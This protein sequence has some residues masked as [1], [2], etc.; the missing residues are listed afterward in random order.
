VTDYD[1]NSLVTSSGMD[2]LTQSYS[3]H[4]GSNLVSEMTAVDGTKT[5]Y[6]YDGMIRLQ[7]VTDPVGATTSYQYNID[8]NIRSH[9]SHIKTTSTFPADPL[10]F[11]ELNSLI[12]ISYLDGLGR[13][14]QSVAVDQA[15]DGNSLIVAV[16]YDDQ[17][18][19]N[20]R[21]EPYSA[22][23][24][25]FNSLFSTQ[26]F[27]ETLYVP[28]PLNRTSQVIPPSFGTMSYSYGLNTTV[29]KDVHEDDIPINT[30]FQRT[31]VDGNGNKS[32]T[33]TDIQGRRIL[34]QRTNSDESEVNE[35][36]IDHEFRNLESIIVPPGSSLAMSQ[37]NYLYVHDNEAKVIHKKV[38]SKEIINIVYDARDLQ[39]GFQDSYMRGQDMPWF[40]SRYDEFGRPISSG[41]YTNQPTNGSSAPNLLLTETTYG[42]STALN[43][44]NKG[45]ITNY[46]T[47][48]LGSNDFIDTDHSYDQFGRP[49][50]TVSNNVLQVDPNNK[51]NEMLYSYDGASNVVRTS[52][53]YVDHEG[54]ATEINNDSRLDTD[55]RTV[56]QWIELIDV[57]P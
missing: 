50:K 11:S 40:G 34:T 13:V 46:K 48:L 26:P 9:L 22:A 44:R 37:L 33:F 27:T 28:S 7:K 21:Y 2:G 29:L 18:R 56:A 45:K 54:I 5:T 1:D 39:I 4:P 51:L 25:V 23:G 55:G 36:R 49:L 12:D 10:G 8:Q 38:P 20:I 15:Y 32:Q 14:V 3:Y 6:D 47:R 35:T 57:L 24:S 43:V 30:L 19:S 31:V 52:N 53:K 41:F 42:T 16:S 17:G